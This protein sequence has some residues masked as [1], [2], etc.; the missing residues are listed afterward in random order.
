MAAETWFDAPDAVAQGFAD[1]LIEPVRIAARFDIGRFRNAPP[2]LVE[3]VEGGG[4]P[5]RRRRHRSG[6]GDR[7][8]R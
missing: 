2:V 4:G 6:R 5:R 3:A 7:R 1:R 8:R